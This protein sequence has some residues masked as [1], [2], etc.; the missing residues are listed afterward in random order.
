MIDYSNPNNA[1][2]AIEVEGTFHIR[3]MI[4]KRTDK[5]GLTKVLVEVC[6]YTYNGTR[7]YHTKFKRISTDVWILPK[8][9]HKK[10]E[11]VLPQD[12]NFDVKNKEIDKA[13]LAVKEYI[14]SHGRQNV[15]QVYSN[16][17]DLNSLDEFF[18]SKKENRKGLVEYFDDYISHRKS[19]GTVHN[20]LKEFTTVKNR[21]KS[22]DDSKG[23]KTFFEDIDLVWSD[24]FES[25][26]LNEAE[27]G[28]NLGYSSGTVEKTYTVLITVLNHFYKRRKALQLNLTDDFRTPNPDGFKRGTKSKNEANPLSEIQLDTLYNHHFEENHLELTRD[29]F[30][31]QCYTG[32]RYSDAFSIKEEH[33]TDGVLRYTPSKTKRYNKTIEQP[34]HN[35]AVELLNK[36]GYDM[37]GLNITNQAYNR[38]LKDMFL[39]LIEKYPKLKFKSD[40]GTHCGR[41]SFISMCVREKVDWKTIL[42]WV[43]QSS[44]AIMD[45]YIKQTEEYEKR[46]M[47]RVNKKPKSK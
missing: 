36:Y 19:T 7:R 45:R 17:F 8:Y 13:F 38:D 33:I 44:Y 42:N 5:N 16:L 29:R 41:D 30:L 12:P 47:E 24:K 39:K 43:G 18:P 4:R 28:E 37:S 27:N 20:T 26:L 40:Y 15:D 3:K 23:K 9:W 32:L 34:L 25:W 11:A 2:G 10:K 35:L 21:I 31:W 1:Y 6:L 22:Y 46:E 14:N